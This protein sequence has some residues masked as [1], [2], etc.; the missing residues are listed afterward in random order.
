MESQSRRRYRALPLLA[1]PLRHD[2][3]DNGTSTT[4]SEHSSIEK[5]HPRVTIH[6]DDGGTPAFRERD[7]ASTIE[8]FFDLF[9]VANLTSFTN[10][11]PI[12]D[13]ATLSSYIGFFAILWFTWLQVVMF[14]VRFGVDSLFERVAKL[15][16]L[17]V[18]VTFAIIG[19]NFDLSNLHETYPT[20]R[21]LSICLF[22]SK[23]TLLCQY[24]S[25][26][27]WVKKHKRII[28][29]LTVHMTAIAI[30][31]ILCL[32]SFFM[33]NAISSGQIYIIWYI[34]IVMEALA[35]FLSSSYWPSVSFQCTNLSER[36]G[37]L[38]LIILGEGIIVLTKSMTYVVEGENFSKGVIAQ[39][40]SAVLI[41]YFVYMLYFDS[42]PPNNTPP[43]PPSRHHLW[44]L[45]HFP[46]HTALVLLMEGTSRFITWRN[47]MEIVSGIY[48]IYDSIISTSTDPSSYSSATSNNNTT[49]TTNYLADQFAS[50]SSTILDTT[51][52]NPRDYNISNY[53]SVLRTT[54]NGISNP[55]EPPTQ[56]ALNA[57]FDILL[58]LINATF[59]FFHIEPAALRNSSSEN[60]ADGD[61]DPYTDLS[62]TLIVYDLVFLYF[63]LA[64]GLVLILLAGLNA[65]NNVHLQIVS[66]NTN[67]TTNTKANHNSWA[68]EEEGIKSRRR[69]KG[70][71]RGN[72]MGKWDI[73]IYIPLALR[74]VVGLGLALVAVVRANVDAEEMF[75]YSPWMLPT[76]MLGLGVVVVGDGVVGWVFGR[77]EE[78]KGKGRGKGEGVDDGVQ[79]T[80]KGENGPR[81]D[82]EGDDGHAEA[83]PAQSQPV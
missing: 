13:R 66:I 71:D 78:G 61:P 32:A 25:V 5:A 21:Q 52:A 47:A 44:A 3:I 39:I 24:G 77:R 16:H 9:F 27:F 55:S 28:A 43:T 76:V 7:E 56:E 58:T 36:C 74:L 48:T 50:L 14:D 67:T 65:L 49:T 57:S 80:E 31:A 38:T 26:M 40:I 68:E 33:F 35:V 63:F 22:V 30:G 41:I 1:S 4:T 70:R 20:M 46:F 81:G 8:L 11:H 34:V 59:R 69:S 72:D 83:T 10:V 19:T 51:H 29:P 79:A 2:Y 75:L 54:H 53:L 18:M 64:A 23:L 60:A 42:L 17:G 73:A 6:E 12:D 45:V 37:L 15:I 82:T 62:N